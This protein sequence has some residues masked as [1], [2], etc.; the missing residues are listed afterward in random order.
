MFSAE[1]IPHALA[2]LVIL[3]T[4][5]AQ[6]FQDAVGD[7]ARG[8][9]TLPLVFP[10]SSRAFTA[11]AI[12]AWALV[13]S[14]YSRLGPMVAFPFVA[15]GVYVGARFLWDATEAGDRRSYVYYNVSYVGSLWC[16]Q[17]DHD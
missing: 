5:Q 11:L 4:V 14:V 10:R 9:R 16:A 6:D 1:A 13:L 7:A 15:L 2:S 12:P 3:T 8:R 17:G